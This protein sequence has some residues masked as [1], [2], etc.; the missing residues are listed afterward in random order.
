[1]VV[2]KLIL[3]CLVVIVLA[4]AVKAQSAFSCTGGDSSGTGGLVSYTAGIVSY[5]TL[6]GAAGS[7][8]QGVQQPYEISVL[9]GLEVPDDIQLEISAYPNPARKTLFLKTTSH[10][11][12]RDGISALPY[13]RQHG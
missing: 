3:S 4:A 2:K 8:A 11:I 13:K 1:M 9:T 6:S 5:T 12:C 10:S 7:V